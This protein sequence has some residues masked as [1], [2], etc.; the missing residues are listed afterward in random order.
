LRVHQALRFLV[1]K[2]T[3]RRARAAART[4]QESYQVPPEEYRLLLQ[5]FSSFARDRHFRVAFV[6]SPSNFNLKNPEPFER[7]GYRPENANPK[8]RPVDLMATHEKMNRITREVAAATGAILVD[9]DSAF[10]NVTPRDTYF[11]GD[12]IHPAE[13]GKDLIAN[14]LASHVIE[15]VNSAPPRRFPETTLEGSG[16]YRIADARVVLKGF[17][18]MFPS[19][20]SA[21][22]FEA[23][24]AT[25][26][27]IT[28]LTVPP[29]AYEVELL[30]RHRDAGATISVSSES[31]PA[32]TALLD[33]N[34]RATLATRYTAKDSGALRLDLALPP[35]APRS[36]DNAGP[37]LMAIR[38]TQ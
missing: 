11:I 25:R 2:A 8:Y 32:E 29:G 14:L 30:F 23:P 36:D 24:L 10:V 34:G 28:V 3:G 22:D 16:L 7:L 6:T 37:S 19:S 20:D 38:L 17:W 31:G 26:G 15:A 1:A 9:V 35:D 4:G 27:E 13:N 18:P 5:E 33:G 12:G 21:E